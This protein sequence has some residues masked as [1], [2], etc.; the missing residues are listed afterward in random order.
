M[1]DT[2]VRT[3]EDFFKEA[4]Q[5]YKKPLYELENEQILKENGITTSMQYRQYM[6]Q[7]GHALRK[8]DNLN[9]IRASGANPHIQM[10]GLRIQTKGAY[11]FKS[12]F[13]P[14]R[15]IPDTDVKKA[16]IE[17]QQRSLRMVSPH[18]NALS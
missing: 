12:S 11:L 15:P 6:K 2:V 10:S 14:V 13:D 3:N 18:I 17:K 4:E 9:A 7:N 1:A 16:Y 8:L 5:Q